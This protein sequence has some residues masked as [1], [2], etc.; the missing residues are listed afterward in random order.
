MV[1]CTLRVQHAHGSNRQLKGLSLLRIW[2]LFIG[3]CHL[4]FLY[5]H[6]LSDDQH[7]DR[8]MTIWRSSSVNKSAGMNATPSSSLPFLPVTHSGS[9]GA[10]HTMTSTTDGFFS[11]AFCF[12]VS[13]NFDSIWQDNKQFG[14]TVRPELRGIGWH[15]HA[16]LFIQPYSIRPGTLDKL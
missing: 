7:I 14:K 3:R 10:W 6:N 2:I 9:F 15:Y 13:G 8:E 16:G 12:Y 1:H 4:V 11:S 5:F